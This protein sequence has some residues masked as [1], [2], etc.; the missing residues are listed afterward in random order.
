MAP[1]FNQELRAACIEGRKST[2]PFSAA[3][4]GGWAVR[5]VRE[6]N[7]PRGGPMK[8][9]KYLYYLLA[10]TSHQLLGGYERQDSFCA[11]A[12]RYIAEHS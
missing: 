3:I 8:A 2:V 1:N 7:T 9:W 6:Y 4:S 11:W 12:T 5:V 10:P